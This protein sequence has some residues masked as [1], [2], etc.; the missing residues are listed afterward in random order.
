MRHTEVLIAVGSNFDA[1]YTIDEAMLKLPS[2][3]SDIR[4]TPVMVNPAIGIEAAD[5]SNLLVT[6]T[7]TADAATL[8]A[9]LKAIE[10]HCGDSRELREQRHIRLDLDLLAFGNRQMHKADWDRGYIKALL[11]ELDTLC[12]ERRQVRRWADWVKPIQPTQ[13]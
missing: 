7:T 5:F 2:L 10:R 1:E 8:N 9:Q 13:P 4:F 11:Q 6:G 12:A 3:L